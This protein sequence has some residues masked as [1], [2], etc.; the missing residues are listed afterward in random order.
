[1]PSYVLSPA[2]PPA[3]PA[4]PVGPPS[5][6]SS[7]FSSPPA[8]TFQ[9]AIP[10][11]SPSY[12]LAVQSPPSVTYVQQQQQPVFVQQQQQQPVFVQ[13]QQQ[14]PIIVQQPQ[15]QQ[16]VVQQQ[17]PVVVQQ[18]QPV[19]VQQ[20]QQPVLVQQQP[21]VVQQQR[22]VLVQQQQPVLVQQQPVI[23]RQQRPVIVQQQAPVYVQQQQQQQQYTY[24]SYQQPAVQFQQSYEPAYQTVVQQAAQPVL[25]PVVQTVL[26]PVRAVFDPV[27][28]PANPTQVLRVPGFKAQKGNKSKAKGKEGK[29][30]DKFKSKGKGPS[31]NSFSAPSNSYAAPSNSY[32][33][34][35][36]NNYYQPPANDPPAN[37]P[38]AQDDPVFDTVVEVLQP[39][40]D[41][42]YQYKYSG[43]PIMGRG[44]KASKKLKK[45]FYKGAI[46]L[47]GLGAITAAPIVPGVIG[48]RKRDTRQPNDAA[49]ANLALIPSTDLMQDSYIPNPK[50]ESASMA[51]E[52]K[53]LQMGNSSTSLFDSLPFQGAPIPKKLRKELARYL[54]TA[55]AM[56]DAECLQKSF[57]ENLIELND[58]P[59]Q[60][61]FLFFYAA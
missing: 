51:V 4:P 8:Q 32:G 1:L 58:S 16:I 59:F 19:L 48:R 37:D 10:V 20:Q 56:N 45:L 14:Q 5:S 21:I 26:Q 33:A 49:V 53:S 38:P 28:R 15:Q 47:G 18:Q 31:N 22:P 25:Q 40:L 35:P 52:N 57:C 36:S 50:L 44:E 46:L 30:K 60:D 39:Q 24:D 6:Y 7:S 43:P 29:G 12:Q 9:D 61:S 17:R 11:S 3:P 34:P 23:V 55:E 27:Y 41:I 54:P 2:S 42:Q 13:Q